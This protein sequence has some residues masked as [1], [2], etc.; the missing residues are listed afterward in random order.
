MKARLCIDAAIGE[1]RRALL[2]QDGQPFRLEIERWSERGR[3]VRLGEV[4]WGR[5]R[6]RMP[7]HRG[8]FVD[9]GAA[10]EGPSRE[11]V[12]EPTRAAAVTE[13]AMLAFRVK[14]EAWADK[15]A[16][17]SLADISPAL[18]APDR[19]ALHAPASEDPFLRGIEIVETL[20]G[21]PA[22][23]EIDDAIEQAGAATVALPGGGD[24]AIEVTRGLTAIDVDAGSRIAEHDGAAF[25]LN[26][27]LAAAQEAARQ[28][29]LRGLAGL[30]AV[31]FLRMDA[32]RDQRA[33]VERFRHALAAQL[34]RASEVL[35]LSGLGLCEAAIARRAR[36]LA[37]ALAAAPDEREALD[38]LRE[39]ESVGLS[40]R[41]SRIHARIS[42]AAHAWLDRN[43]VD[44]RPALADRIG[45]RWTLEA[46]DGRTGPPQ[47][48]SAT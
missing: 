48:W 15:S 19:P 10:G 42:P 1:Q 35:E 25:A 28:I 38:A 41:A 4:W 29:S 12:V 45:R 43:V 2:D 14:S 31:D 44:W 6:A 47:V 9:L 20:E 18:A 3:R 34:G 40:A 36:P 26:L 37:E 13:G 22:R 30:L 5:V 24:I 39:I 11:G 17:L 7:G 27:N 33:V 21:L 16:V 46:V 23:R 32:R 8:W